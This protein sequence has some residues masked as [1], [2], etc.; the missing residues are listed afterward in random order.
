MCEMGLL[1]NYNHQLKLKVCPGGSVSVS[2]QYGADSE[3]DDDEPFVMSF[4]FEFVGTLKYK[5]DSYNVID[6]DIMEVDTD[7]FYQ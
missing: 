2:L 3:Q 6:C 1:I 7:A 4:P 5:G